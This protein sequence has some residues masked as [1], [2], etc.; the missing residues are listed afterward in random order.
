[1]LGKAIAEQKALVTILWGTVLNGG[2]ITAEIR[3]DPR[4]SS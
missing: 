1:M 2:H 3:Q 4:V